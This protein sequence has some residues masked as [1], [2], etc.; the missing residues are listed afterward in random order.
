MEGGCGF[1]PHLSSHLSHSG[2]LD[3]NFA[4]LDKRWE[5]INELISKNPTFICR[6]RHSVT[7]F[8]VYQHCK[9]GLDQHRS[10]YMVHLVLSHLIA[11]VRLKAALVRLYTQDGTEGNSVTFFFD[12]CMKIR[13]KPIQYSRHTRISKRSIPNV[14]PCS[15]KQTKRNTKLPNKTHLN[16]AG[17]ENTLI[18]HFI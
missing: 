16:C 14:N 10:V 12:P 7:F 9:V 2:N 4:L 8:C 5:G 1:H 3:S 17:M 15:S 18:R 11:K 6:K 13:W